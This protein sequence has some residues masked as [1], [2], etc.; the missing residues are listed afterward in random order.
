MN[1][2][3][4]LLCFA[5]YLVWNVGVP[6]AKPIMDIIAALFVRHIVNLDKLFTS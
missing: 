6:G 2:K 4:Y 1:R 5:G 3:K